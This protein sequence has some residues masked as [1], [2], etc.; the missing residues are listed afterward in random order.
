LQRPLAF[1]IHSLLGLKLS[2]FTLFVCLTGSL[3]VVSDELEW[4]YRAEWRASATDRVASWQA[5]YEAARRAFPKDDIG[6]AVAGEEP[7][8]ATQFIAT[9][10][11][12]E[13]RRIHVD[14]ATARVL[15]S[16]AWISLPSILR[17]LHYHLFV[18]D[19]WGFYAVTALGFLLMGALVSGLIVYKRF[20][21]GFFRLPR[22]NRGARVYWGDLHRLVG[23]WSMW[24]VFLIAGTSLWYMAERVL[25]RAGIDLEESQRSIGES[26]LDALGP[27]QPA[28]LPLDQLIAIAKSALPS[29]EVREIWFPAR[30]TEPIWIRGQAKAWLV[31]DRTNGVQINPY[32]GAVIAVHDAVSMPATERWVHTADPLHFGDFGG[33]VS[34]LLWV[35]FG[36]AMCA[37]AASG[38]MIYIR[39]TL[40]A[41]AALRSAGMLMLGGAFMGRW[42]WANLLAVTAVPAAAYALSWPP[43]MSPGQVPSFRLSPAPVGPWTVEA[44]TFDPWPPIPGATVAWRLRFCDGCYAQIRSATLSIVATEAPGPGVPVAGSANAAVARVTVPAV[45]ASPPMRLRLQ[46]I[47]WDGR[48]HEVSWPMP[49]R[50]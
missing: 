50:P 22:R 23:V 49:R 36:V 13:T 42:R 17:A 6:F 2:L 29:L 40:R 20:W 15:G 32:T 4:L 5:Q 30:P 14:P 39:R 31:R 26:D 27:V 43:G 46:A 8:L 47:A 34:K 44:M 21:Q 1:L 10:P 3:A 7:Y 19:D 45:S 35:G 24:F 33:L 48:R 11:A 37:S 41:T 18:P 25:D 16:S 28:H 9:D 38:A 12:G